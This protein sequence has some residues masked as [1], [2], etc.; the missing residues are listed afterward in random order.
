[1]K[2]R[3]CG[4]IDVGWT[5]L[6]IF[7]GDDL[8]TPVVRVPI[9]PDSAVVQHWIPV[10]AQ[11][12][13][14]SMLLVRTDIPEPEE[15]PPTA[16]F[17]FRRRVV[18]VR[19]ADQ[20]AWDPEQRAEAL[21]RIKKFVLMKERELRKLRRDVEAL[22]RVVDKENP[23]TR[24]PR[25]TRLLVF[26]RD[27]GRCVECGSTSDLQFDHIIPVSKGGG[28]SPENIQILCQRCNLEKGDRIG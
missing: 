16:Q 9:E 2:I 10:Q 15:W 26:D 7:L 8:E 22:E 4:L 1:M 11:K 12:P 28:N 14:G 18:E 19:G 13:I 5:T 25:E 27:E 24:I 3:D 17:V 6:P 20:A 23:R 21:L